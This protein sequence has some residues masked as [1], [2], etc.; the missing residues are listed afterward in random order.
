MSFQKCPNCG[1][2][3]EFGY[4][5]CVQCGVKLEE[6]A[7]AAEPSPA[8][9]I[10]A[11]APVAEADDFDFKI[12]DVA[13]EPAPVVAEA[14][15][16]PVAEAAPVAEPQAEMETTLV[17]P[18]KEDLAPAAAAV[19]AAA[20]P[21]AEPAPEP[22]PQPAPEPAPQPAPEP[23]PQPAPQ[24]AAEFIPETMAVEV[25]AEPALEIRLQ[26]LKSASGDKGN[27]A[28]RKPEVV[29]GRTRG[30]V[31]FPQDSFVGDPHALVTLRGGKLFVEDAGSQNGVYFRIKSPLEL[32]HGTRFIVGEQVLRFEY[33]NPVRILRAADGT[34]FCGSATPAWKFRLV[35]LLKGGVE[36]NVFCF[37]SKVA[38]IGREDGDLNFPDDRYIS[39]Q[40]AMI[41]NRDG[42]F[43]LVDRGSRNGTYVRV[44]HMQEL[45][46]GDIVYVGRSLLRVEAEAV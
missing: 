29:V 41:E 11:P 40:H 25:V 26:I 27:L 45:V 7:P 33:F 3:V 22:A 37:S 21:V 9:A 28:F 31:T 10:E 20:A 4:L 23:A 8:P 2:E 1:A 44:E 30:D 38:T 39:Y 32:I 6:A 36:G 19:E 42:K 43:F 17:E 5:F 35:Q 15:V 46:K 34:Y 24:A 12:A 18:P 13:P 16:E 14:P